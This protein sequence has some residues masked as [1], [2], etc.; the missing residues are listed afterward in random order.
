MF[1]CLGRLLR[2]PRGP[3]LNVPLDIEE[4]VVIAAGF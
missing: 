1:G 3:E 2:G 4:T